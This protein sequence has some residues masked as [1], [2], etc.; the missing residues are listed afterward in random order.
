MDIFCCLVSVL[1]TMGKTELRGMALLEKLLFTVLNMARL[2]YL[3]LL[4]VTWR[5]LHCEY[6]EGWIAKA[7]WVTVHSFWL[8]LDPWISIASQEQKAAR[9]RELAAQRQ[10]AHSADVEKNRRV[11]PASSENPWMTELW[12]L[13][14]QSLRKEQ[15]LGLA[16]FKSVNERKEQDKNYQKKL[17]AGLRNQLIMQDFSW[18]ISRCLPMNP[19]HL[20]SRVAAEAIETWLHLRRIP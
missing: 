10:R 2:T 1:L 13:L 14:C 9:R 11:K 4:Q 17:G 7:T 3:C 15:L 16:S 20:S 8:P 19:G 5:K 6:S 18:G 12:M